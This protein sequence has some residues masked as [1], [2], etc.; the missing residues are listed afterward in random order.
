[1]STGELSV[2]L[3]GMGRADIELRAFF[4]A[5]ARSLAQQTPAWR[6]VIA[7]I[8]ADE[9]LFLVCRRGA[10]D[11]VGV[12]P[13]YRFEG[14][15]GAL[16]TSVPQPGPLGGIACAGD[17][18]PEPVYRA[19][20]TAFVELAAERGC[21]LASLISNPIWPDRELYERWLAPDYVLEN[22]CLVLDLELAL[23]ASGRPTATKSALRRNLRKAESGALDIDEEQT[24]A[25]VDAWYEIHATR[26][27]EIGATPLPHQLFRAALECA[28]PRGKARFFFVRLSAGGE[29]VAGGFYLCHGSVID[30]F[31][32]SL[33]SE[34]A[35]LGPNYLLALHSM[36][37]AR[38]RGLRWY[39]WQASPPDGGVAR[40]KRQWGS[41][42]HPYC[43]LTR[44]TGDVGPFL[45]STPEELAAE[46]PWHYVLPYDRLGSDEAAAA[47]SSREAA[48][49]AL[50]AR[51]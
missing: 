37:W 51:R 24:A 34:F 1:M 30:A 44:V 13:A 39:N 40:F 33:R 5:S 21:A 28:V 25:N 14:R 2:E 8:G 19:L 36:Q 32:P 20:L 26:H 38:A 50:E 35:D 4:D 31:M 47:P 43:Y 49:R 18:E 48:W 23:D 46:Y 12:L 11:I 15:L 41:R 22:S 29:M 9:P 3:A 42:E 45:A 7:R 10:G 6:D 27:R 17:C 16:L